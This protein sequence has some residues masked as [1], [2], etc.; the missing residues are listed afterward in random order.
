[1]DRGNV[2]FKA[3]AEYE[4][5]IPASTDL[6]VAV[7]GLS[8]IGQALSEEFVHRPER[9]AVSGGMPIGRH[10][11][12]GGGCHRAAASGGKHAGSAGRAQEWSHC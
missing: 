5:V 10:G 4:P 12:P 9:V 7:V 11:H 1:M 3:P 8:V 6:V 2:P